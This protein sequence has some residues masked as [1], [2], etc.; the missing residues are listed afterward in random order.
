MLFTGALIMAVACLAIVT[1]FT[2]LCVMVGLL[3]IMATNILATLS[4]LVFRAYIL[5]R[6]MSYCHLDQTFFSLAVVRF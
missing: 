5:A 2:I 3:P 1:L 4:K 6:L